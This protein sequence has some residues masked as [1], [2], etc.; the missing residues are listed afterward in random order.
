[1]AWLFR[2]VIGAV[3]ILI[4]GRFLLLTLVGV[5]A[6]SEQWNLP[7]GA[8][9]ET[10]LS[11][12]QIEHTRRAG[13]DSEHLVCPTRTPDHRFPQI[14]KDAAV[15]SEDARFFSHGALDLRSTLRALW[16]SFQ[17][18]R[19]GGSTITQQL[20]RSLL[21]RN[22]YSLKRKLLEAVLAVRISAL[23]T[24]AEIL[25]RY[26][27]AVPHARNMAGFDEPARHYFGLGVEDLN[28]AEAALLV[29]MLPE[30]NA[31]DPIKN[32]GG[33]LEG[34][35][36]VLKRLRD[37][38][39]I[40]AEDAA[41]A[42]E[43]LLR[44]LKSKRLRRGD[45]TYARIEY[46]PYRDLA[47]REAKAHGI[48]LPGNYRL[49]VYADAGLQQNL[50]AQICAATGDHEAAGVFM[51]PGGEVLAVSG[52]CTYTGEWNRATDIA[53]S[54]GS[55]GKLFP[56]I[57][58]HEAS[59]S[60]GNRFSTEPLRYPNWPAEPNPRC[61]TKRAV[62]L[63]YALTHSCNRPW[64]E[65]SM[66][67]GR[68]VT[69]IV[70]R[71]DLRAPTAPALVP[72]GG[73]QTS[74]MKIA[75]AY[76][77]LMNNGKLPQI[78]FLSAV[79]GPKGEILGQPAVGK[80]RRVMSPETA[81]DVLQSLRGP[82]KRGTARDANSLH[83][84]VYG[85]TGTSSRNMDALFV[86][87]ARDF[88]GSLW[89][90]HDIPRP[91]PGVHGGGTPARSFANMTD[92][93]YLRLARTR[94]QAAQGPVANPDWWGEFKRAALRQP[95]FAFAAS[96]AMLMTCLL[97]LASMQRRREPAPAAA[98]P[99]T[100]IPAPEPSFVREDV[101]NK[102]AEPRVMVTPLPQPTQLPP[103]EA[104]WQRIQEAILPPTVLLLTYRPQAEAS[105]HPSLN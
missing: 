9:L 30:P 19:Q 12:C 54:I 72:I 34:A 24:P 101:S 48:A 62:S 28:L 94:F 65:A 55:T 85:K 75:Q 95:M 61:R 89:L 93:Y 78:R 68:R 32:P 4:L 27:N 104:H 74:P 16:H 69:E 92:Y 99:E 49:I 8:L 81:L 51:R 67:L 84:L 53:R 76:A 71:F 23:L 77:S 42:E 41:I 103:P 25:T 96:F 37:H 59:F 73:V 66:R 18:N 13:I 3:A 6:Q 29:G 56:L 1:V 63:D 44:R 39:K 5:V 88:V 98:L 50:T 64:T 36:V 91:M 97:L 82:V 46:R 57:G 22:E 20:A 105:P 33:A 83:A 87:I 90:G 38:G 10:I 52:S 45:E 40:G 35:R 102:S 11:S 14:L 60:L 15:A 26:L 79:I 80:P 17:G 7:N 86:G 70:K 43:E 58:V 31:R 100:A 2:A 21:L 47:L